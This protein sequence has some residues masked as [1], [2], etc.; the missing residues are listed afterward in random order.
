MKNIHIA[1]PDMQSSHCQKRVEQ[2]LATIPGLKKVHTEAG[3][4]SVSVPEETSEEALSAVIGAAGY[5]VAGMTPEAAPTTL[6]FR[7]NINCGGCVAQVKPMLDAETGI[8]SWQVDTL[9][10]DK[11]L[12]V[13]PGNIT[14]AD[15]VSALKESG[16]KAEL[17]QH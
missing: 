15:I 3:N 16:F 10:R 1:I 13:V 5:T 7:T 6:H 12:S 4:V 9:T 8:V 14:A 2:A 17:I 11:I